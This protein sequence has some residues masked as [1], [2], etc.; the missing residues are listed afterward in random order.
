M[1][2]KL[3][4]GLLGA[5]LAGKK[6][7]AAGAIAG[8]AAEVVVKRVIPLALVAGAAAYAY[9][10]VKTL[11]DEEFGGDE[12]DYAPDSYPPSPSA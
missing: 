2:A 3:L 11:L 7:E 8:I 5:K 6:H 4:S 12:P 1:I 10:K 9:K